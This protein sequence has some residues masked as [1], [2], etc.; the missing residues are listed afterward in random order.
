MARAYQ[1]P[2][3]TPYKM[4]VS[5]GVAWYPDDARTLAQLIHFADF[6]MYKVKR[7]AKGTLEEFSRQDYSEDSFLIS[8]RDA[9]DRLIDQ[10]LVRFA[11]QP[12]LSARTGDVYGFELLM[13]TNVRELPDPTTVLRLAG[14]EGKLP[15][16]ERLTWLKGLETV[17]AMMQ[18]RATPPGAMFFINSVANQQLAAED[19]RLV[20]ER[21]GGFL[22]RLV[23]EVTESERSEKA[24]TDRKLAFIRAHGGKIAIDDY[25]TGYNSEVALIQIG[26]DIVKLDISFVR[27]VD[28]DTDKQAL[29]RNLISYARERGI[30]VVAEGVETREEM[31]TLIRFG[32]DYLQGYYLGQPQYQPMNPDKLLRREIQRIVAELEGG[33]E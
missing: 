13:R 22:S 25:G 4:R 6:A 23:I 18:N 26:A 33:Q 27:G 1:L 29:I 2:D 14:A 7:S 28:T 5:A 11:V 12:I 19:E 24:Y 20:E 10:Q 8:G 15:H 16:I 21:Y 3:G 9:L 31:R 32:V 17:K 30:A